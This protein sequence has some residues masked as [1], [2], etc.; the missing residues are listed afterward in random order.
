VKFVIGFLVALFVVIGTVGVAVAECPCNN[1]TNVVA[2]DGSG[3][4]PPSLSVSLDV[5]SIS[6]EWQK[7]IELNRVWSQYGHQPWFYMN[8]DAKYASV[9][10]GGNPNLP[11][12]HADWY[13]RNPSYFSMWYKNFDGTLPS[14][15]V[16]NSL[17]IEEKYGWVIK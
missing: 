2:E 11:V 9:V 4:T 14:M 6:L 17:S 15:A 10:L 16:W 13:Y 7:T 1:N 8:P 5:P 12:F 3:K